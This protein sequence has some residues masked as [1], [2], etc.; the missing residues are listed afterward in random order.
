[1]REFDDL[2]KLSA[3]LALLN[4]VPEAQVVVIDS[5]SHNFPV[6]DPMVMVEVLQTFLDGLPPR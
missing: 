6:E 5:V 1:M 2:A 4:A 3:Q